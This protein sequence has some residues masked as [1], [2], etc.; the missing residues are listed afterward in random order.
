MGKKG[1]GNRKEGEK[2]RGMVR[3]R[4]KRRGRLGSWFLKI[5]EN[6]SSVFIYISTSPI[7]YK[8]V[9]LS[10]CDATSP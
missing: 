8:D 10:Y 4:R 2:G 1:A 3:K 6:Y 9:L 5:K 7:Q